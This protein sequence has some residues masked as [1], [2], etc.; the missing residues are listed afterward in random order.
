M[1]GLVVSSGGKEVVQRMQK[2]ALSQSLHIARYFK[3]LT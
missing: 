3:V 1:H 2:A